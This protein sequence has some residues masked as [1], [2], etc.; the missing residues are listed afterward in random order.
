[1]D[2]PL[3]KYVKTVLFK[4]IVIGASKKE[5]LNFLQFCTNSN[6]TKEGSLASLPKCQKIQQKL[7]N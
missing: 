2:A 4:A 7:N 1:M 6:I 5:N 3:Q